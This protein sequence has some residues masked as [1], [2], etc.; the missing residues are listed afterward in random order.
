MIDT[1]KQK[2]RGPSH[3]AVSPK[4]KGRKAC[5]VIYRA[6]RIL[7]YSRG[8]RL[9]LE[10]AAEMLAAYGS[11]RDEEGYRRGRREALEAA[12]DAQCVNCKQGLP[13]ADMR[14]SADDVFVGYD[15]HAV[16]IRS[17]LAELDREEAQ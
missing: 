13:Y 17:L 7:R 6:W 16:A 3:T 14:H 1:E 10:Q 8:R 9:K 4:S 12:R 5:A 15:C 11:Q 2:A